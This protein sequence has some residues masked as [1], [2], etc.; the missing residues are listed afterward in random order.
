SK[1]RARKSLKD[2]QCYNCQEYGH[3]ANKCPKKDKSKR[4]SM[5][6]TWDESSNSES[7]SKSKDSETESGDDVKALKTLAKIT[8]SNND[9]I[10]SE[11]NL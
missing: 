11:D 4:K 8:L 1:P 6:A 10:S 5:L 9:D 3:L 7:S 2:S